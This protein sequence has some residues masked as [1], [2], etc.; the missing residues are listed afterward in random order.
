MVTI[1]EGVWVDHYCWY[2]DSTSMDYMKAYRELAWSR[3]I[4]ENR[5]YEVDSGVRI[6]GGASTCIK[7]AEGA[8]LLGGDP[9]S[10]LVLTKHANTCLWDGFYS[11]SL[12]NHACL[13]DFILLSGEPMMDRRQKKSWMHQVELVIDGSS[14]SWYKERML[15]EWDRIYLTYQSGAYVKRW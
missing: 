8:W 15:A 3:R 6:T 12:H 4:Y 1:R 11:D 10:G 5:L 14:R 9:Y 7:L 2:R 13:P